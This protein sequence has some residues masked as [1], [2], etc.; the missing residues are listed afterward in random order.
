MLSD[1]DLLKAYEAGYNTSHITGLQRVAALA[2][3][4][5]I[6]APVPDDIP[7]PAECK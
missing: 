5:T 3:A 6:A 7:T 1:D 4:A 2:V